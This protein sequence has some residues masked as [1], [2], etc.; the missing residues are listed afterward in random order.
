MLSTWLGSLPLPAF[1][2]ATLQRHAIAQPTTTLAERTRLD[3]DALDRILPVATDV[4]V[5]ARGKLLDLPAPRDRRELRGYM[6]MGIGL[7]MRHT[8]RCDEAMRAVADAFERDVGEAQVQLFI[9]PA[10]THGFGWHYDDEDVFIA[11]TLG[12]K[13]Y[14]FRENTVTSAIAH[15]SEFQRFADETAPLQTATIVAGDFLYIPARWWHM[16]ICREDALSISVGVRPRREL[17]RSAPATAPTA[18]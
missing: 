9:T 18:R 2:D 13:D 11:Q 17:V 5:V 6:R 8:E 1:L 10:G 3:W 7:C 14:Y 12:H 4:L 15:P 16:A